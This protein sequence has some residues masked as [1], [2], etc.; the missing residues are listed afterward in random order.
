MPV[1][2]Y[3]PSAQIKIFIDRISD[4]LDLDELKDTFEYLGMKPDSCVY[5]KC[6]G[7]FKKENYRYDVNRFVNSVRQPTSV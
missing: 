5:V 4:F 7:G 2:W 6:E 1:Y 3:S